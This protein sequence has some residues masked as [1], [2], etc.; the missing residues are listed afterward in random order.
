MYSINYFR[1]EDSK[2]NEK[3]V[4]EQIEEISKPE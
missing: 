4:Q 1:S 2:L 3:T